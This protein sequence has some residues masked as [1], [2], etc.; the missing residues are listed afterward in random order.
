M[1]NYGDGNAVIAQFDAETRRLWSGIGHRRP[2]EYEQVVEYAKALFSLCPV[3]PGDAVE[4]I[5]P[6]SIANDSGW[7]SRKHLFVVGAIGTA[8]SIDW[9]DGHGFVALFRFDRETWISTDGVEYETRPSLY[10][11]AVKRLRR[12]ATQAACDSVVV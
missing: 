2:S 4:L 11:L 7:F 1:T 5:D 8:V 6:P 10:S 12:V 9:R 3:Q